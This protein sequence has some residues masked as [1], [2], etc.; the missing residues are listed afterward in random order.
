[1]V[2]ILLVTG[3]G[4]WDGMLSSVLSVLARTSVFRVIT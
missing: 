2:Y 1:M 3:Y 4:D